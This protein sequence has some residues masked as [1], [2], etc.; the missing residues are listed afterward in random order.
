FRRAA[1]RGRRLGPGAR[2][3]GPSRAGQPQ[4]ERR[5]RAARRGIRQPARPDDDLQ[6]P[7]LCRSPRGRRLSQAKG[8]VPKRFPIGPA[9][10]GSLEPVGF[11]LSLPDYNTAIQPLGGH[12]LPFG[13]LRFLL[14]VKKI[15][16][17]RVVTLGLKKDYRMRGIQS[18]MFEQGLHAALKRGLTGC[19]V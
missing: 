2:H 7:V 16:T 8:L 1:R 6:P 10:D 17:L 18:L 19:E 13:W 15:R 9:A 3:G 14:G 5:G 11:M 12:L 4:P